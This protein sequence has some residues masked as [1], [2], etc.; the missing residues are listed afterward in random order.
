MKDYVANWAR[1]LIQFSYY[2]IQVAMSGVTED[3]TKE[4][5]DIV[6][7]KLD[8]LIAWTGNSTGQGRRLSWTYGEWGWKRRQLYNI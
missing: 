6:T 3:I 5:E 2:S 7:T 1:S 8:I 4:V